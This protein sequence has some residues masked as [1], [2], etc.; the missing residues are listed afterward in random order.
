MIGQTEQ[1]GSRSNIVAIG[2]TALPASERQNKPATSEPVVL[3]GKAD[4]EGKAH[5][6]LKAYFQ[7]VCVAY[8]RKFESLREAIE[9]CLKAGVTDKEME[10][11][12]LEVGFALQTYRNTMTAIR[13]DSGAMLKIV[14]KD[15]RRLA[16]N[17]MTETEK[18][19]MERAESYILK[20]KDGNLNKAA[21]FALALSRR[22]TAADKAAKSK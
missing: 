5:K 9:K 11:W 22:F 10:G 8:A 19:D 12:A 14:K 17:R 16:K 18:T 6:E 20:L 21:A 2:T 7:T 13:K 15:D 4:T 1:I 3:T